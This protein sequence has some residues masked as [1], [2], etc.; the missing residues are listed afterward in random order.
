V[1]STWAGLRPLVAGEAAGTASLSRDHTL[2]ISASGLVTITGGK[3]TTYRKMGEDTIDQAAIVAGL[4]ERPSV[5]AKL[6]IH[7]HHEDAASFGVLA[8][9]GADAPAIRTLM[10]ADGLASRL[11]AKRTITGAE[12]VW[13]VR[14]EMARTVEDVLSR[15]TR[16]LPLDARAAIAMAP[17][18]AEL[19]AAELGRDEAWRAAQVR[20]FTTL[21][22]GY[23]IE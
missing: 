6:R 22:Q 1:L 16:T 10:E 18:V 4:E 7:G 9:Y 12:V 14:H 5:T 3:W 23:L 17:R 19:I 21:A 8:G 13:A 11:H 15:R 20:Q 2:M